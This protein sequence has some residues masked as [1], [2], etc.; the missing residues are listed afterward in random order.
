MYL[1]FEPEIIPIN[2]S[3]G[4]VFN[5]ALKDTSFRA[6]LNSALKNHLR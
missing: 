4:A 1:Q 2:V 3:F 6:V 5:S